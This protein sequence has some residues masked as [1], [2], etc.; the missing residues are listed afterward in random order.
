MNPVGEWLRS[1]WTLAQPWSILALCALG[2]TCLIAGLFEAQTAGWSSLAVTVLV[3]ISTFVDGARRLGQ[4]N[5]ASR[6]ER[7][8]NSVDC[9]V[10]GT[11]SFEWDVL[12][13]N[14]GLRGSCTQLAT[15]SFPALCLNQRSVWPF[16]WNWASRSPDISLLQPL[17]FTLLSSQPQ[18]LAWS[19]R[20]IGGISFASPRRGTS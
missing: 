12:W 3:A 19:F 5:R 9:T 4:I 20:S 6:S 18:W 14:A 10:L 11:D 8:K 1:V 16:F 17:L 15:V 13:R 7:M 2:A